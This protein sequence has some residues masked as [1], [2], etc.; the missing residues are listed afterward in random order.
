MSGLLVMGVP[1]AA[2][3]VVGVFGGA[4]DKAGR[5][6]RQHVGGES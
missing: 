4:A 1:K 3:T 5:K 2:A 6:G